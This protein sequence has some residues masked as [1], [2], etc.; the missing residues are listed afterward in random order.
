MWN[1]LRAAKP[2]PKENEI[3]SNRDLPEDTE[4]SGQKYQTPFRHTA[5]GAKQVWVILGKARNEACFTCLQHV[6]AP[7]LSALNPEMEKQITS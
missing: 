6:F 1:A 4:E 2:Q 3:Y 5:V 7:H